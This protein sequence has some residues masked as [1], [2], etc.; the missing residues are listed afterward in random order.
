MKT[1]SLPVCMLCDEPLLAH[2]PLAPMHAR[3]H[4]ECGLRAI[5]GG[6]NHLKGICSCCGGS[7]PPD[8]P[9]LSR[10]EAARAAARYWKAQ[11]RRFP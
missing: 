1:P 9:G 7:E 8:P 10:R 5:V 4:W 3:A 6:L 2:E 11:G